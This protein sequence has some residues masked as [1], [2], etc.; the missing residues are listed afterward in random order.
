MH[1]ARDALIDTAPGSTVLIVIRCVVTL[2]PHPCLSVRSVLHLPVLAA[3]A[4]RWGRPVRD[5]RP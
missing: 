4:G 1:L 2:P 3:R 5:G